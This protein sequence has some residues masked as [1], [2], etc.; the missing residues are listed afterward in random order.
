MS[1][2]V[3]SSEERVLEMMILHEPKSGSSYSGFVDRNSLC[4]LLSICEVLVKDASIEMNTDYLMMNHISL[5]GS[6]D[7]FLLARENH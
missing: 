3:S 4:L 6:L 1:R 2:S 5:V 7:V